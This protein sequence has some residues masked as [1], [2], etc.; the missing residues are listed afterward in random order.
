MT[1]S[2]SRAPQIGSLVLFLHLVAAAALHAD[3][4][5]DLSFDVHSADGTTISG[6]LENVGK[7]WSIKLGGK[8]PKL[9]PGRELISLR[10]S[11]ALLPP[12]PSEEHI[13]LINGDRVRG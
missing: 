11:H 7:D 1:D 10:R 9:V 5:Q 8:D 3:G 12:L 4:F 13:I 6:P 2:I